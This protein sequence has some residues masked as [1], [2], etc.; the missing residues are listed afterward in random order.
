MLP[1]LIISLFPHPSG[2]DNS[3]CFADLTGLG[4]ELNEMI[5]LQTLGQVQSVLQT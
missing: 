1:S 3:T 4:Q 5:C 2:A